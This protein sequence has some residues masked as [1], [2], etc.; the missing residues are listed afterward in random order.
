MRA[1]GGAS[2]AA[3][4]TFT[5]HHRNDASGFTLALQRSPNLQS[6]HDATPHLTPVHTT[7]N[8]RHDVLR[9]PRNHAAR[10]RSVGPILS[11]ERDCESVKLTTF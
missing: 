10:R 3:Y 1:G 5:Y 7:D 4:G 6:W 8:R 9:A 11:A 2:S